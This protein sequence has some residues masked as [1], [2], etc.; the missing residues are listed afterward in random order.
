M[1]YDVDDRKRVED[2]RRHDLIGEMECTLADIVTGGQLYK[3]TLREK[4]MAHKNLYGEFN[5]RHYTLILA[6]FPGLP[7]FFCSSVSVDNNT[8][9]RKGGEMPPF[10]ICVLL[11]TETG[12][13]KKRSR[14]GNKATLIQ[15]FCFLKV[16][17]ADALDDYFNNLDQVQFEF[18]IGCEILHALPIHFTRRAHKLFQS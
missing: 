1:V 4:G 7:R 8:R 14:P 13:Q 16:T 2:T 17:A 10:R 12:E 9:M 18:I 5:V 3:R 6:S 11:S 15:G